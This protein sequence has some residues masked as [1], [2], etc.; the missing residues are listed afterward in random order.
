MVRLLDKPLGVYRPRHP[1]E[2]DLHRLFRE[3]FDEFRGV[4]GERYARR[5]GFWRPVI[6]KAVGEFLKCGDLR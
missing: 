3:H 5:I 6:D 2:S 4:Y 1:L